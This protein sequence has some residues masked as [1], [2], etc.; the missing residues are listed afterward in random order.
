MRVAISGLAFLL[1]SCAGRARVD[2][3]NAS[4]KQLDNVRIIARGT[5][6]DVGNLSPGGNR[7]VFICPK[8]ESSLEVRFSANQHDRKAPADTY[9][10]CNSFYH[11]VLEIGSDLSATARYDQSGEDA[12]AAPAQT[13][14]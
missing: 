14:N 2:V 13:P 1:L 12:Q 3:V 10:E 9:L 4:S 7:T 5:T 11:V 8:G 6:V